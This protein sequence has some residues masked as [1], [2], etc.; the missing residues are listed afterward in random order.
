MELTR[1]AAA[2]GLAIAMLGG[3]AFFVWVGLLIR[4]A[5]VEQ[6]NDEEELRRRMVELQEQRQR[7][8][9]E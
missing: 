1:E 2:L 3:M 7:L 4:R 6:E 9:G 5:M 8:W